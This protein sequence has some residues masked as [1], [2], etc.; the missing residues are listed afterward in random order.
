MGQ[1]IHTLL[2]LIGTVIL[3][4]AC[5]KSSMAG[6]EESNIIGTWAEKGY[7]FYFD[8]QKISYDM[9]SE[10]IFT[11]NAVTLTP[12]GDYAYTW[13]LGFGIP[14]YT[15]NEDGGLYMGG[16]KLADWSYEN[17]NISFSNSSIFESQSGYIKDGN[18]YLESA[19]QIKGYIVTKDYIM[20][21]NSSDIKWTG[22][23]GNNHEFKTVHIFS[24]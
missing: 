4:T 10:N 20:T 24:K 19:K 11:L 16:Y 14:A 9:S 13:S 22:E 23:D 2:P 17:M 21:G 12:D 6:S 1:F 3:M 5:D 15:F 7:E 18:L 8:G